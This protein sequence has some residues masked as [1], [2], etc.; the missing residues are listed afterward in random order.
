M[1][2][3]RRLEAVP[4]LRALPPPVFARL[5]DAAVERA[6]P[7]GAA[8]YRTGDVAR[9][10]LAVRSGTIKL[11][12]AGRDGR[13]SVRALLGPGETFGEGLEPVR[14]HDAVAVEPTRLWVLPR[15]ELRHEPAYVRLLDAQLVRTADVLHAMTAGD[16]RARVAARLLE[17]AQHQGQPAADGVLIGVRL[18]Q[19]DLGRMVGASRETVNKVLAL[20]QRRGWLGR[21]GSR[22]VL[23]DAEA[24]RELCGD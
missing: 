18:T 10:L 2:V 17:L 8:A 22:L 13:E 4:V 19:E 20:F 16:T 3:Q 24:L 23:T 6:L 12:L 9:H 15:D 1:S 11:C 7:R 5:A 21:H 14:L